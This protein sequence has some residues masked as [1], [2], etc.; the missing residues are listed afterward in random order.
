VLAPIETNSAHGSPMAHSMSPAEGVAIARDLYAFAGKAF[1]CRIPAKQFGYGEQLAAE[2][3]A[4]AWTA[5]Q[6]ISD[7][8]ALHA[9]NGSRLRLAENEH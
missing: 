8:V 5:A 7:Y 2:S 4:A 1:L 9:T 6:M 3:K